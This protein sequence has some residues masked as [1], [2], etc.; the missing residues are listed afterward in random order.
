MNSPIWYL[1]IHMAH[2]REWGR[3]EQILPH[4]SHT[5][6]SQDTLIKLLG[7]YTPHAEPHVRKIVWNSIVRCVYMVRKLD[8]SILRVILPLLDTNSNLRSILFDILEKIDVN[9]D[10]ADEYLIRVLITLVISNADDC[11]IFAVL[12]RCG[13]LARRF[14]HNLILTT[15][16]PKR[17]QVLLERSSSDIPNHTHIDNLY[18]TVDCI[19]GGYINGNEE[20]D[21]PYEIPNFMSQ[22]DRCMV[23][24][25]IIDE[26]ISEQ[27]PKFFDDIENTLECQIRLSERRA[28]EYDYKMDMVQNK[29]CKLDARLEKFN[30]RIQKNQTYFIIQSKFDRL[31]DDQSKLIRVYN[32]IRT[33]ILENANDMVDIVSQSMNIIKNINITRSV[34]PDASMLIDRT[35]EIVYSSKY[36]DLINHKRLA[37]IRDIMQQIRAKIKR[38][39]FRFDQFTARKICRS[40][41]FT[42]Y[43]ILHTILSPEEWTHLIGNLKFMLIDMTDG[44]NTFTFCGASIP[45]RELIESISD[46]ILHDSFMYIKCY[47]RHW[48]MLL[49]PLLLNT[50]INTNGYTVVIHK[51]VDKI[52]S[53][54]DGSE[55]SFDHIIC[56]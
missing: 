54:Q 14:V 29:I 2:T 31:L 38:F 41:R 22:L 1:L 16:C 4:T 21:P 47:L 48:P 15:R 55:L 27:I 25:G 24:D 11:C 44:A 52:Y 45:C 20:V 18:D 37:P 46:G 19:V 6:S 28:E 40:A 9:Q 5:V 26:C 53:M 36:D 8:H 7:F 34:M 35:L 50:I 12:K 43:D 30:S 51:T 3:F 39:W 42:T 56:A 17:I 23:N 13:Y 10:E 49:S 33:E 32:N